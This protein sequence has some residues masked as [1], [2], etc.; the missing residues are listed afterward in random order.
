MQSRTGQDFAAGVLF[1]LVGLGALWVGWDYPL[2]TA[3]RPGTGVLPM[4]LS[5]SLA[6]SGII[7]IAKAIVSGDI[8][9]GTWA[10]R[11]LIFVTLATVAF[12]LLIDGAGLV[13]AMI[14]SLALAAV[15]TTET[16]WGEFM[17]FL[18]IMLVI[19]VG[20]FIIVLGMPI[21]IWP[22]RMPDFLTFFI[23]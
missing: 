17:F 15:G 1:L 19:G 22:Q 13:V 10:W 16:R 5:C 18:A 4:I 6:I 11:P 3:H 21:P 14:V 8:E 20:T 23:R 2:G 7:L 9:M 12:G